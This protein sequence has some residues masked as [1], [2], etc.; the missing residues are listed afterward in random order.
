MRGA[1]KSEMRMGYRRKADYLA[2]REGTRE[3]GEGDR[4]QRGGNEMGA[5]GIDGLRG[6][7]DA[8]DGTCEG[9][10]AKGE[11]RRGW[12]RG[13]AGGWVIV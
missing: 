4:G 9:C 7:C 12:A 5:L 11:L 13:D 10:G 6:G 8:M 1:A 3:E 2:G